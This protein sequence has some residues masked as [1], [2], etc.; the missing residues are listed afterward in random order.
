MKSLK[1][2]LKFSIVGACL[3]LLVGCAGS[4]GIPVGT[5]ATSPTT[6]AAL[7]NPSTVLSSTVHSEVIAW[8]ESC[9]AYALAASGAIVGVNSGKIPSSAFNTILDVETVVTPMCNSFPANPAAAI[10]QIETGTSDL[11]LKML[12]QTITKGATKP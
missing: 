9:D 8:S 4:V 2:K 11:A 3:L 6:S 5:S 1:N 12:E 10:S 7:A